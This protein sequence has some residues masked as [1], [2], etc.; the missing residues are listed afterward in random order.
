MFSSTII[1]VIFKILCYTGIKVNFKMRKLY[2]GYFAN[3]LDFLH[4]FNFL[5]SY[6]LITSEK[7]GYY[8]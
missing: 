5:F 2:A 3:N 7:K 6:M 8:Y 4:V 1:K